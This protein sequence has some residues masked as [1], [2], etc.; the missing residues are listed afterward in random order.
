MYTSFLQS[1]VWSRKFLKNQSKFFSRHFHLA[2]TFSCRRPLFLSLF[3]YP[4]WR[5]SARARGDMSF[6][7]GRI[8]SR[9]GFEQRPS[10]AS[11]EALFCGKDSGPGK[12][13]RAKAYAARELSPE[14]LSSEDRLMQRSHSLHTRF[15]IYYLKKRRKKKCSHYTVFHLAISFPVPY[16]ITY[17]YGEM[18]SSIAI[19][20]SWKWEIYTYYSLHLISF[21]LFLPLRFFSWFLLSSLPHF[22]CPSFTSVCSMPLEWAS[23]LEWPTFFHATCASWQRQDN[24]HNQIATKMK[25]VLITITITMSIILTIGKRR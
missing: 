22:L 12:P 9:R 19:Y 6:V 16:R 3:S 23:P 5:I 14:C 2:H 18:Y 21:A 11:P 1:I 15:L 4:F 7:P 8:F 17:D 13:S 10:T 20:K 24:Q 25:E